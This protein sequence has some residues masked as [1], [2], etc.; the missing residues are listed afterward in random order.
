MGKSSKL[1]AAQRAILFFEL[2]L[3]IMLLYA[4][5]GGA[6]HAHVLEMA[7][8]KQG[9]LGG[10]FSAGLILGALQLVGI[11]SS[12]LL[13]MG[14]ERLTH[15]PQEARVIPLAQAALSLF[16]VSLA[17]HL[18]TPHIPRLLADGVA[19]STLGPILSLMGFVSLGLDLAAFVVLGEAIL[20]VRRFA[21]PNDRAVVHSEPLIR[22]GL[23]GLLTARFVTS[24]LSPTIG[25]ALA[26]FGLP[27]EWAMYLVR[28]PLFVG[29]YVMLLW[30]LRGTKELL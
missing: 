16:L 29:L 15:A 11:V 28:L 12:V 26:S 13:M 17:L 22:G 1:A 20:R 21:A 2:A 3:I 30:L 23:I 5:I 7:R 14:A 6:I 9:Y 8:Q 18:L 24:G 25:G 4:V 27:I 10:L 19:I